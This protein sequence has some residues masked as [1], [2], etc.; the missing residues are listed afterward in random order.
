MQGLHAG[1]KTFHY[2][3]P[4]PHSVNNLWHFDSQVMYSQNLQDTEL[5]N[6]EFL[7]CTAVELQ[8]K[9]FNSL[10]EIDCVTFCLFSREM[11]GK[12]RI[13]LPTAILALLLYS[14][15][16]PILYSQ[17]TLKEMCRHEK[18]LSNNDLH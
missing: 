12:K 14:A 7:L 9:T 5:L 8:G 3:R 16:N 13:R 1:Q 10:V 15:S 18:K 2:E 6:E 4:L 17:C 11:L